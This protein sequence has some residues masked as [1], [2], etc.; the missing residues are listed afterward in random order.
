MTLLI[1]LSFVMGGLSEEGAAACCCL[2]LPLQSHP[3][4]SAAAVK[5]I[6]LQVL[7]SGKLM[8]AFEQVSLFLCL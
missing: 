6:E 1:S 5:K 7:H 2:P 4:A 8:L 3:V